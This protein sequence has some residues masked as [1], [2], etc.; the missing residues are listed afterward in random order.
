MTADCKRLA[1]AIRSCSSTRSRPVTASVTRML[2]LNARVQ[3]EEEELIAGDQELDGARTA[4]A[5]RCANATA[6]AWSCARIWSV[7]AAGALLDNLLMPPLPSSHVRQ[8]RARCHECRRAAAPRRGAAAQVPLAED[9]VV[10]EADRPRAGQ[11][12]APP[13]AR[14]AFDDAHALAV[15]GRCLDEQRIPELVK[16][17]PCGGTGTPASA[18]MRFAA[19][20][21]PRRSAS[22]GG[23][24][25][26]RPACSTTCEPGALGGSRTPGWTESQPASRAARYD[27]LG[28]EV[29]GDSHG[30]TRRSCVVRPSSSGAATATVSTPSRSQVRNIGPRSR[31]GSP[32]G[33]VGRSS[34][35]R[36]PYAMRPS[37]RLHYPNGNT[38]RS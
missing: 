36:A 17:S 1:A 33:A 12:R 37:R 8:G 19:S 23:P 32:R 20:L 10:T 24:I 4:V 22:G 21:S 6:A 25:Q 14:P 34:F 27:L 18:A 28:I 7:K 9:R 31:P 35:P 2:H 11:Q 29:R 30:P 16:V 15:A 26:A 13:R 38:G 3:L 5:D